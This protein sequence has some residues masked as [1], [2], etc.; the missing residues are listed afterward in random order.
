MAGGHWRI[1]NLKTSTK[2]TIFP[3]IRRIGSRNIISFVEQTGVDSKA[4]KDPLLIPKSTSPKLK[5]KYHESERN[6]RISSL[7]SGGGEQE[8]EPVDN[9][10]EKNESEESDLDIEDL[11]E[12]KVEELELGSKRAADEPLPNCPPKKKPCP[13]KRK[14]KSDSWK[15]RVLN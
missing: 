3:L 13:P 12:L 11:E 8:A 10:D 9:I 7:T 14:S 4:S 5:G 2:Y 15:F 1:P 6:I